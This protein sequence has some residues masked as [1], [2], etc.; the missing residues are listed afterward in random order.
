MQI[1]RP[2]NDFPVQTKKSIFL[3]GPTPRSSRVRS[4]R[5]KAINILEQ[6]DYDGV[7]FVPEPFIGDKIAQIEWEDKALNMADCILFWIPRDLETMP[8]FT[9]NHEHGEWF[10]SGKVVL[11][12]PKDAP[13]MNYLRHKSEKYF[14]P[15]A[16]TLEDAIQT[17]LV[18]IGEGAERSEGECQVPLHIWNTEAFQDWYRAQK[19]AGNRLDGARV[20]WVFRVGPRKER[21]FLWALHVNV[22]IAREKRNK[23]NEVIIPRPDISTILLYRKEEPVENSVVIL[24]REFRSPA[25]TADGYVW[26][27]P[28]G[29]SWDPQVDPLNQASQ[30]VAEETG[31]EID[32]SRFKRHEGRQQ[33]ATLAPHKAHLFSVELSDQEISWLRGQTGIAHGV[34]KDTE[35]TYV[36]VMTVKKILTEGLVDWSMLGMIMSI[37]YK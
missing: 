11:G 3:V 28:G 30:E 4:W 34:V 21:V 7:V 20:E 14:N 37:L 22:Y 25:A 19:L 15:I 1:I 12:A 32:K 27:I 5:P 9:T 10:K 36:E 35:R 23:T 16:N 8:A 13:H 29:S 6:E 18:M 24:I 26:E 2:W 17:A 31:L 33:L